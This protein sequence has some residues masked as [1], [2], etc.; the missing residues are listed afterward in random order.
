MGRSAVLSLVVTFATAAAQI[1]Y[2]DGTF[3]SFTGAAPTPGATWSSQ[4]ER[5]ADAGLRTLPVDGPNS[6]RD[7]WFQSPPIPTGPSWR[8]PRMISVTMT[9]YVF[10]AIGGSMRAYS[11]AY[12]RYSADLV[13]WS[14]WYRMAPVGPLV[15]SANQFEVLVVLPG[16]AL[17]QYSALMTE[18]WQTKPVWGSDEHEFFVW[19]AG[20]HRD[21]F[22]KEI[23][24]IG[25]IQTRV[26][27]GANRARVA[28]MNVQQRSSSSGL[29]SI[30][31]GPTRSNT[32]GPW[33]FDLAK[34]PRR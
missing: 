20:H 21:F 1:G 23:P 9:L 34:F 17:E 25:Y 6:S 32:D 5:T 13:H 24:V 7:Y 18:W 16:V 12:L 2:S 11:S 30:P 33:F 26:E 29:Q 19:L 22:D 8:P 10:E 15:D 27:G 4:M 31:T 28:M 3:V 14:T